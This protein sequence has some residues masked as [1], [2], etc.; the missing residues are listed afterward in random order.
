MMNDIRLLRSDSRPHVWEGGWSIS[1]VDNID[2][3]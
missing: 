1:F 2:K 3:A